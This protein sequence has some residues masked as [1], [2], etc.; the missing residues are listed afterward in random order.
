VGR[1]AARAAGLDPRAPVTA[2]TAADW[3]TLHEQG[4]GRP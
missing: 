4:P 1:A 3:R 2:L